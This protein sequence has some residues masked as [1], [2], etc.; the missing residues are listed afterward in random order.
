MSEW[1]H[2]IDF[3]ELLRR[4]H[5]PG[6]PGG[7]TDWSPVPEHAEAEFE[8]VGAVPE[9]QAVAFALDASVDC[10]SVREVRRVQIDGR[11]WQQRRLDLVGG[12]QV[13]LRIV[14][15]DGH[16]DVDLRLSRLRVT[17]R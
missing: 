13:R 17:L 6:H 3:L 7:R 14:P 1:K 16:G 8:V 10:V 11:C 9:G 15:V 4:G 2:C 5:L 12:E